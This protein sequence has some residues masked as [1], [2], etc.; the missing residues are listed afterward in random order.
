MLKLLEIKEIENTWRKEVGS[1]CHDETRENGSA[2]WQFPS[3][4][5]TEDL[6]QAC[7]CVRQWK[8]GGTREKEPPVWKR[9]KN[10]V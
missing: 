10:P 5:T 7:G 9:E 1:K 3:D 4:T 6:V 8:S 2:D